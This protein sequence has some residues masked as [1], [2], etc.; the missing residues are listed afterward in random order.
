ME[1]TVTL[2]FHVFNKPAFGHNRRDLDVILRENEKGVTKIY[3]NGETRPDGRIARYEAW[4]DIPLEKAYNN[5]FGNAVKLYNASQ[6]RQD[7]KIGNYL[8]KVNKNKQLNASYEV[9][10]GLYEKENEHLDEATKEK[11]L[12]KY[13]DDFS[14]RNP[15]FIKIG[16]FLH[17]DENGKMHVHLDFIPIGH[18]EKGLSIRN[19]QT[20]ALQEMG[21]KTD[22]TIPH[23]TLMSAWQRRER[24][25][26]Q[27][28]A[29]EYNIQIEATKKGNKHKE[30]NEYIIGQQEKQ[31]AKNE[32]TI[33]EQDKCI[34]GYK[35]I[36]EKL[37]EK[38][39]FGREKDS[40]KLDIGT[41]TALYQAGLRQKTFDD[42][43]KKKDKHYEKLE[44]I[45]NNTL[46]QLEK[47]KKLQ[48]NR[49]ENFDALVETTAKNLNKDFADICKMYGYRNVCHMIDA[50]IQEH[51]Q[52][53]NRDIYAR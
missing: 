19:S 25:Y 8:D 38:D 47:K 11:I 23:D 31:I 50:M 9:I 52:E 36:K 46:E 53:K 30:K 43:V 3:K 13:V 21:I 15:N 22:K 10:I 16:A 29:K 37:E 6:K 51:K 45:A 12:K 35:K 1:Q 41:A 2:Q 28:I 7:R 33:K 49:E 42:E 17:D 34:E 48:K 20:K 24:D 4:E 5:I 27:E 26:I 39:I 44:L 18:Y 32:E 14:E 40:I